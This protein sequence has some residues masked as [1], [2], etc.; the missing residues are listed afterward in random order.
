MDTIH[1]DHMTRTVSSLFSRRTLAGALALSAVGS[2]NLIEAKKRK[3]RRKKKKK[4]TF[5]DF[6]CV[7]VG[8]FC[9]DHDQCCSGFCGVENGKA[10]CETH[11]AS[12]CQAGEHLL[13][14]GG[15]GA[16]PC[17]LSTGEAATCFTTTGNGPFCA[18][19]FDCFPCQKD[20]DCTP[21]CGPRAACVPCTFFC[22][23]SGVSTA[24][25]RPEIGVPCTFPPG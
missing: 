10:S 1:F 2:P 24:C 16:V 14:C 25:A 12:T 9:Q 4:V 22:Q 18:A 17:E 13:A 20:A 19:H 11:D 7:N 8:D 3:R 23:S 6:G 15:E 21:Y 5:N